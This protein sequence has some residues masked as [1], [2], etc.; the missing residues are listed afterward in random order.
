MTVEELLSRSANSQ[1]QDESVQQLLQP[2]PKLPVLLRKDGKGT[3][4]D[5][6]E[7]PVRDSSAASSLQSEG[8]TH[9]F[10]VISIFYELF[11]STLY[12]A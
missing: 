2:T 12:T 1:F 7:G 11:Y 5:L 9:Y 10:H 3:R 6:F 8:P 4:I